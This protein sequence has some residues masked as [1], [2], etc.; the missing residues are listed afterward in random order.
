MVLFLMVAGASSCIRMLKEQF[1]KLLPEEKDPFEETNTGARTMGM[2]FDGVKLEEKDPWTFQVAS[3]L[4]YAHHCFHWHSSY[5]TEKRDSVQIDVFFLSSSAPSPDLF[6]SKL[7]EAQGCDLPDNYGVSYLG[8]GIEIKV[9]FDKIGQN[10]VL[11]DAEWKGT[12]YINWRYSAPEGEAVPEAFKGAQRIIL[13]MTEGELS[14]R[15]VKPDYSTMTSLEGNPSVKTLF[16]G[17]QLSGNFHFKGN[18]SARD[19]ASVFHV[20][21]GTFDTSVYETDLRQFN[22]LYFGDYSPN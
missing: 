3:S 11:R 10:A 2:F 7:K 4:S 20:E 17:F 6:F 16:Y 9:P 14:F 15:S 1:D 19:G 22:P 13:P 21:D 8:F 5:L 18:W 12:V